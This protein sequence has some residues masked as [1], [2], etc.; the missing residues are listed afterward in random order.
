MARTCTI[1]THAARVAIDKSL[2]D[3]D[4]FRHIA[5]RHGVSTGSLQ[6]HKNDHLSQLLAESVTR[7]PVPVPVSVDLAEVTQHAAQRQAENLD[8]RVQLDKHVERINLLS[9]A[10]DRWLRD[11]DEPSR[12]TLDPR[13]DDLMV[14]YEDLNDR[15]R[16]GDPKRKRA[17][18]AELLERVANLDIAV[19]VVERRHADPRELVLKTAESAKSQMSLLVTVLDK[20]YNQQ[21]VEAFQTTVLTAINEVAP[22]VRQRIAENI[23]RRRLDL[24]PR[25]ENR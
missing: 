23:E 22:D 20:L 25:G 15:T 10:C 9:D 14:L 17:T 5:A 4:S 3:G 19:Q 6:R 1:C 11:P 13:A 24:R 21:Q 18:L 8:V 12:Y 7:A 2:I 16:G